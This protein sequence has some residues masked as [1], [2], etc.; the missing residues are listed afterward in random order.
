MRMR[1]YAE[2]NMQGLVSQREFEKEKWKS[3]E[4][5]LLDAKKIARAE[6]TSWLIL[7]YMHL[8]LV[9]CCEFH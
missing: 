1:C 3:K 8:K 9:P 2:N 5:E 7:F 6:V 4:K